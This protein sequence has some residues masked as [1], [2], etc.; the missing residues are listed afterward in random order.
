M[1]AYLSY[2]ANSY[3]YN[4]KPSPHIL[5]QYHALRNLRKNKYIII[6]KHD[7]GNGVIVLDRKLYDKAV[8]EII[9]DT[10]KFEKLNKEPTLKREASLQHFLTKMNMIDFIILVLLL[11]VSMV[12]LKCTNSRLVIHFLNFVQ[13]FDL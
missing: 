7:K 13:L 12:I 2:L 11:L 1:K 10:S 3:F 4:Y 6:I 9:S 8:Q 5:R